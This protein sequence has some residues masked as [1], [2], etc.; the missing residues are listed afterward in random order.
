M[1]RSILLGITAMDNWGTVQIQTKAHQ[2]KFSP[3]ELLVYQTI[4]HSILLLTNLPMQEQPGARVLLSLK[5][6]QVIQVQIW[7][8]R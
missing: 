8:V 4:N 2:L 1:V 7:M 6:T 3:L 5:L